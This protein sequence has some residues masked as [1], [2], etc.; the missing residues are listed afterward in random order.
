M[1]IIFFLLFQALCLFGYRWCYEHG[2]GMK[3][4]LECDQFKTRW[5]RELTSSKEKLSE[6]PENIREYLLALLVEKEY[7]VENCQPIAQM[8]ADQ[9]LSRAQVA[10]RNDSGNFQSF[11]HYRAD[12]IERMDDIQFFEL[13]GNLLESGDYWELSFRQAFYLGVGPYKFQTDFTRR[14]AM[15]QSVAVFMFL[16]ILFFLPGN[17]KRR[18]PSL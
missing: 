8:K 14:F 10:Y 15:S 17:P 12:L 2:T 3:V 11:E 6:A 7:S 9:V 16:T 5:E 18:Y 1:R 13:H 4:G